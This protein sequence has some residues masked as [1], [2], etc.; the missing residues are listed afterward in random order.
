M[1]IAMRGDNKTGVLLVKKEYPDPRT[2]PA[3]PSWQ[4]DH[5]LTP[6]LIPGQY[7]S[8]TLLRPFAYVK[9]SERTDALSTKLIFIGV[10]ED[11]TFKAQFVINLDPAHA[12]GA[13]HG[14]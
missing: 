3:Q 6:E 11:S 1:V 5:K 10:L 8:T 4:L 13:Q 9:S 12:N 14:G 2:L 7:V